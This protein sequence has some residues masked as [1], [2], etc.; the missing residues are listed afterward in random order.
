MEKQ[1]F[2]YLSQQLS[3]KRFYH[4]Y[5]VAMLAAELAASNHVNILKA[6]TAGLLHDC[7]KSMKDKDLIKFFKKHKSF[8]Y[9]KEISKF[10]PHL[11]HSFAGEIISKEKMGI[12]DKDIL[13]AIKY[14]T[15]GREGMGVLEKI[16]FIADAA[17]IDRKWRY[18]KKI[19][20][21][22][23]K[24]LDRAFFATLTEKIEYIIKSGSWLCQQTIDTWNWCVLNDKKYN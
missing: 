24:D 1:I 12:K 17:S 7:A 18:A 19:K 6:Q 22:A 11:L 23:K 14:H 9:F 15:L 20:A 4:S 21:L 13:N 16:I 8:K 10:S 3:P 2:D 5:N